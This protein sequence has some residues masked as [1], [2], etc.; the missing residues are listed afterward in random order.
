MEQSRRD[1][2]GTNAT[3]NTRYRPETNKTK[4]TK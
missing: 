2:T 3:L 4:N 1:N